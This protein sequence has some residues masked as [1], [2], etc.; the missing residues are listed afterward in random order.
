MSFVDLFKEE[1]EEEEEEVGEE[2]I[3]ER[4]E[5]GEATTGSTCT[6]YE[7]MMSQE[8]QNEEKSEKK[9]KKEK[10]CKKKKKKDKKTEKEKKLSEK[11][12][13]KKPEEE[14]AIGGSTGTMREYGKY[15]DEHGERWG[16]AEHGV[17]EMQDKRQ[18]RLHGDPVPQIIKDGDT[19]ALAKFI[20][21][22]HE[23]LAQAI[24]EQK[25]LFL[26]ICGGEGAV[27]RRAQKHHGLI[28]MGM[29]WKKGPIHI[30][31]K[32]VCIY[33]Y[34]K[35]DMVEEGL[36]AAAMIHA[37]C[38]TWSSARHGRPGDGTPVPLQDR[39]T[40]IWGIPGLS[41]MDQLKLEEGNHITHACLMYRD[42]FRR[43]H[44]PCGLE[45]GDLSMLWAVPEVADEMAGAHVLKVSY[46]M[47]G[48]PFRKTTRFVAW[49]VKNEAVA[50][51]QVALCHKQYF[52]TSA[53]G[54]CK[55]TGE[56]HLILRGWCRTGALT[57]WGERYPKQFVRIIAK[58][59][60]S[61]AHSE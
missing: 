37:P 26:D 24:K 18:K 1:D 47:M 51:E 39:K 17:P 13:K 31:L 5:M 11:K 7:K 8:Q 58:V 35:K 9:D 16:A 34:V 6:I 48:K 49:S 33:N 30:D 46:C 55:R 53:G 54:V 25:K 56:K 22:A 38:E 42:L 15:V 61:Q 21:E 43:H 40:H 52:C 29:D 57:Q 4:L 28:G 3:Q 23:L 45:N 59:L 50:K 60:C 41:K 27:A 12:G 44:V 20:E 2:M 10:K 36:V 32:L 14:V 19:F